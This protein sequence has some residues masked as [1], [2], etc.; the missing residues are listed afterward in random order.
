[1]PTEPSN[2]AHGW[3][4]AADEDDAIPRASDQEVLEETARMAREGL[5]QLESDPNE[6]K[7]RDVE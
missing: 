1:M 2:H 7:H 4:R 6:P 3:D 5:K